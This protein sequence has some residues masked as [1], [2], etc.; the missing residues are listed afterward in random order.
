MTGDAVTGWDETGATIGDAVVGAA[1]TGAADGAL[2]AATGAFVGPAEGSAVAG[3]PVAGL[4]VGAPDGLAVVFTGALV[5]AGTGAGGPSATGLG[6]GLSVG[7]SSSSFSSHKQ[8]LSSTPRK[9]MQMPEVKVPDV[10][11]FST[12]AQVAFWPSML[13][14]PSD[15][16]AKS[17]LDKTWPCGQMLQGTAACAAT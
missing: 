14:V 7:V 16:N 17:P 3:L 2:V 11:S 6:A 10:A 8:R 15:V 9:A 1:V 13:G 5:G 4:P 12:L